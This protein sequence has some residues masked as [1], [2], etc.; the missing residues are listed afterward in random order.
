MRK[1]FQ[2]YKLD[3]GSFAINTATVKIDANMMTSTFTPTTTDAE[4]TS[5]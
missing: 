5:F 2:E 4:K 1:L 3:T